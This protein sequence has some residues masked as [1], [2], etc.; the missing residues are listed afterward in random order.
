MNN[1]RYMYIPE[2]LDLI[3]GDH[4]R[5]IA[6][7]PKA[8]DSYYDPRDIICVPADECERLAKGLK[9]LYVDEHNFF[10]YDYIKRI[11]V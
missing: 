11:I 9:C 8:K 1:G 5:A 7:H 2:W 4:E 10:I 3:M 6:N